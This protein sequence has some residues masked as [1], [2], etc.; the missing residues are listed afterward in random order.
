[1]AHSISYARWVRHANAVNPSPAMRG[2]LTDKVSLT[3][4]LMAR[5]KRFRVQRLRQRRGLCLADEHAALGLRR[6]TQIRE[7]EVLLRC[8]EQPVVFAH[9]VVPL[10]ANASDW[11]F[12]SSLGERSLGTTLFG[13]PLVRRGPLQFAR[14]RP[15]HPLVRRAAAATGRPLPDAPLHA[16][17]CLFKRRRGVLLVTEVFLPSIAGLRSPGAM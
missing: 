4:K 12:F 2:W 6:R 8:D 9:T 10:A 3:I 5:S 11:P 1:M 15:Q 17:R 7:R 13:D 16:R 14:L